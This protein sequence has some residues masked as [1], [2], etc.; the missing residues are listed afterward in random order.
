MKEI[1]MRSYLSCLFA[2]IVTGCGGGGGGATGANEVLKDYVSEFSYAKPTT[3]IRAW[4]SQTY[5]VKPMVKYQKT[6]SE[7][8]FSIFGSSA[9]VSVDQ[10]TGN[11][12]FAPNYPGGCTSVELKWPKTGESLKSEVCL[13]KESIDFTFG[14]N[15]LGVNNLTSENDQWVYTISKANPATMSIDVSLSYI[16]RTKNELILGGGTFPD[17]SNTTCSILKSDPPVTAT[18]NRTGSSAK[19]ISNDLVINWA[20]V[21]IGHYQFDVQCTVFVGQESASRTETL[22]V[23]LNN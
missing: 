23:K 2:I 3:V 6:N 14:L 13:D 7:L 21:S 5:V 15:N 11:V 19:L 22:K 16:D 12:T 17:G 4:D 18:V 9:G 1:E 20:A 8:V 10:T